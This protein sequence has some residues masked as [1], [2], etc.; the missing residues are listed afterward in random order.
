[1]KAIKYFLIAVLVFVIVVTAYYTVDRYL[2]ND[3]EKGINPMDILNIVLF[4][5]LPISLAL[6]MIE[7]I[8]K[9]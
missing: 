4:L 6:F 3:G 5:I 9:K 8:D 7:R 2:I 1:M